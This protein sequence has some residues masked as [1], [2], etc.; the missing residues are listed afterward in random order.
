MVR[1][2]INNEVVTSETI[3]TKGNSSRLTRIY[4]IP[5]DQNRPDNAA[6]KVYLTETNVSGSVKDSIISTTT[7]KRPVIPELWLVPDGAAIGVKLSLTDAANYIYSATGLTFGTSI[8]Y[9]LA[10]KVTGSFHRIDWTGMVF[11]LVDAVKGKIG[12]INQTGLSI[13]STDATL[14]GISTFSF[15]ALKFTP[16]AG[17]K[18][19]EAVKTLDI[20]LDLPAIVLNTVNF[21]GG[22]I[23]FGESVEVTFTGITDLAHNLSPDYFQVTGANTAI[24][25]GKTGLYNVNFLISA[26]YLY[27]EPQSTAIYPDVLWICGL[28]FGRP[29]V[30][31]TVTAK[32][33]WK[34]DNSPLNY[35]PCRLVS[36]GV[37]QVTVYVENTVGTDGLGTLNFKFFHQRDWSANGFEQTQEEWSTKYTVSDPLMSIDIDKNH[38]NTIGKSAAFSGAYRITLNQND[39]T[40]KAVAYP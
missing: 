19:L 27:I 21:K 2:V 39:K 17:G 1:V 28:G 22:N 6:V 34:W 13:N 31:Y 38:G 37:Y 18:L 33:N 3:R 29:Q 9:K 36:P 11:G 32:T 23:Y 40:I 16:K 30:P 20:N 8:T 10:T 7:A 26:G 5:F 15:D 25:L 24:F 12:P 4:G 14:V 35:A